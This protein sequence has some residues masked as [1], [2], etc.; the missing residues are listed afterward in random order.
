MG[1]KAPIVRIEYYNEHSG[2]MRYTIGPRRYL[3]FHIQ[4]GFH[5]HVQYQITKGRYGR[6]IKLLTGIPEK[7]IK[8]LFIEK[9]MEKIEPLKKQP[10]EMTIDEFEEA[11]DAN[12]HQGQSCHSPFSIPVSILRDPKYVAH[13]PGYYVGIRTPQLSSRTW[14]YVE[15]LKELM[16][17]YGLVCAVSMDYK[18]EDG[19]LR[20]MDGTH[21]VMI[22]AQL[23]WPDIRVQWV[24]NAISG[25]VRGYM[26][27][28]HIWYV[29]YALEQGKAV[30]E[31]ILEKYRWTLREYYDIKNPPQQEET[32]G[33]CFELSG[34]YVLKNKKGHLVHGKVTNVEGKT[35]S[36]AW[37]EIDDDV[38]DP[39][40]GTVMKKAQYYTL[41]DAKPEKKYSVDEAII[42]MARTQH[43]GPWGEN[44]MKTIRRFRADGDLIEW[45]KEYV[46]KHKATGQYV[47]TKD[48]TLAIATPGLY[49]SPDSNRAIIFTG[50]YL[51]HLKDMNWPHW[52]KAIWA[53]KVPNP[54]RTLETIPGEELDMSIPARFAGQPRWYGFPVVYVPVAGKPGRMKRMLFRGVGKESG[55]I[56]LSL[57]MEFGTSP[58]LYSVEPGRV[59]PSITTARNP[60]KRQPKTRTY[61]IYLRDLA[62]GKDK[63]VRTMRA[64]GDSQAIIQSVGRLPGWFWADANTYESPDHTQAY[65]SAP[66]AIKENPKTRKAGPVVI[67]NIEFTQE[68]LRHDGRFDRFRITL[69]NLNTGKQIVYDEVTADK[70]YAVPYFKYVFLTEHWQTREWGEPLTELHLLS[71]VYEHL[72]DATET[73]TYQEAVEERKRQR[74]KFNAL[75]I[76]NIQKFKKAVWERM[77]YLF[78]VDLFGKPLMYFGKNP[79]IPP[80]EEQKRELDSYWQHERKSYK[81]HVY[82]LFMH[83]RPEWT[84]SSSGRIQVKIINMFTGREYVRDADIMIVGAEARVYFTF[85]GKMRDIPELVNMTKEIEAPEYERHVRNPKHVDIITIQGKIPKGAKGEKALKEMKAREEAEY[86]K[87]IQEAIK[88]FRPR[89][90]WLWYDKKREM[91]E[92]RTLPKGK[93]K[94]LKKAKKVDTLYRWAEKNEYQIITMAWEVAQTFMRAMM[95]KKPEEI[96]ELL[97]RIAA[98]EKN[99]LTPQEFH[100]A[101]DMAQK[102]MDEGRQLMDK[103]PHAAEEHV[104]QAI[105]L[106]NALPEL[107]KTVMSTE[108]LKRDTVKE[109]L[110]MCWQLIGRADKMQARPMPN[111]MCV[112]NE[113][114]FGHKGK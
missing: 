71:H 2:K 26:T 13:E 87:G 75:G 55:L 14:E 105:G 79:A 70:S 23:G 17:I 111:P 46:L 77:Y 85:G 58:T 11:V 38:I 57:P 15:E 42:R 5:D 8:K 21:R 89:L 107:A 10:W 12:H 113:P 104:Y 84:S 93:G 108:S 9:P 74:K 101:I 65:W 94:I 112:S 50:N 96:K 76:R 3:A 99:P 68:Y 35:F 114:P 91:H 54:V 82:G 39:T 28:A 103:D 53:E 48:L 32:R 44:P 98:T 66:A 41:L 69:T 20:V 90:S 1:K 67:N 56:Y 60:G 40:A 95:S 109:M 47:T 64:I 7:N 29:R 34:R 106:L 86:F 6:A 4:R 27:P 72:Q 18:P 33:R 45:D 97:D 51:I 59:T 92:L 31:N 78:Q 49:L 110:S 24:P 102:H 88:H 80:T 73:A 19:K 30:P 62:T 25:H 43:F 52:F 37:V 61:N 83:R 22:A 16:Q 36:H 81:G 100:Q 63:F